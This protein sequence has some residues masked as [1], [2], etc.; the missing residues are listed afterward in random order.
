MRY[1]I[2][3]DY[4]IHS[5]L[6]LCSKHPEQTPARI[7]QYAEEMGLE[8][9]VITDHFWDDNAPGMP[10]RYR[11]VD[12]DPYGELPKIEDRGEKTARWYR[13]QNFAHISRS[14]PL[15]VSDKVEFLF[16]AETELQHDLKL[17]ITREMIDKMGFVV[18]PT[19]HMHMERL[20]LTEEQ[21][22]SIEG[23]A[24]A[25]IERIDGVLDMDLP[26]G[27]IGLAHL[28]CELIAKPRENFLK[29]LE[30]LDESEMERV[31]AKAAKVG[32]GIEINQYD[33]DATPK[34]LELICR[35]FKIAKH[36]GCKFYLGSDAHA[37]GGFKTTTELFGRAIDLLGLTESD[38]FHIHS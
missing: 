23:R 3:H 26:F 32:V 10:D 36:Q 34:E 4:H 13:M 18:I 6:S 16:G 38:K 33:F 19:T 28:A 25:W 7:L 35:P 12:Y 31:F 11:D 9:I 22:S 8:R 20:T 29:V 14:L 1:K 5:Q 30:L 2:D 27:K 17:G 37:P 24:R 15:P 21:M